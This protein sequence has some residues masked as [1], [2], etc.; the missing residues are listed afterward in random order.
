MEQKH[1]NELLQ[2][3]TIEQE[4]EQVQEEVALEG[5]QAR[6]QL[7]DKVVPNA[8]VPS[9]SSSSSSPTVNGGI[10]HANNVSSL[11]FGRQELLVQKDEQVAEMGEITGDD[12]H[13]CH[14]EKADNAAVGLGLVAEFSGASSNGE[15]IISK[16]SAASQSQ[17]SVYFD[18]QDGMSH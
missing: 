9:F 5:R 12:N 10:G 14:V 17:N 15:S 11:D 13:H 1:A 3:A 8:T 6:K 7:Q 16:D 2:W 18:K 4:E